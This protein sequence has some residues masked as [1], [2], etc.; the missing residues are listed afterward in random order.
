MTNSRCVYSFL[1]NWNRDHVARMNV[2]AGKKDK[3]ASLIQTKFIH[4][5]CL[6]FETKETC[7]DEGPVFSILSRY[8]TGILPWNLRRSCSCTCLEGGEDREVGS[9]FRLVLVKDI[10]DK[11]WE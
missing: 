1:L 9:S 7:L 3:T 5:L 4:L 6:T 2:L 11:G 10:S 8:S